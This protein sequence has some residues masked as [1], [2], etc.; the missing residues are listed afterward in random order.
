MS[1]RSEFG[2][3]TTA[4]HDES[5]ASRLRTAV[6]EIP[7]EVAGVRYSSALAVS[8][9]QNGGQAIFKVRDIECSQDEGEAL[10]ETTKQRRPWRTSSMALRLS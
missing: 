7:P 5:D 9:P 8:R 6:P 2:N 10:H 4:S 1:P 3:R